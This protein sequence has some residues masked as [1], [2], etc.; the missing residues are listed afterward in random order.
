M[1]AS[2]VFKRRPAEA[3]AAVATT[4]FA[5]RFQLNHLSPSR[6]GGCASD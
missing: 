6:P 3:C 5:A 1:I 2:V 4:I